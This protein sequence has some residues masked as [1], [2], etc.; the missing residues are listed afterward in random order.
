MKENRSDIIISSGPSWRQF[1]Y[2][3]LFFLLVGSGLGAW[4]MH[5]WQVSDLKTEVAVLLEKLKH[6][7]EKLPV[8]KENVVTRTETQI[9]YVPKETIKY[10]D[11]KTGQE[12]EEKLDGKFDIGKTE[13]LYS[14][15]G[16]L[17][18]FTKTDDEKY[19]F[20]KNMMK[21]NQSS[22]VKLEVEVP[23]VDKTKRNSLGGWYTNQGAAISVGHAPTPNLEIKG[24]VGVPDPRKL[25]GAGAEIRF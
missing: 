9:A 5:T 13:F 21:L 14:V 11:A 7:K 10:I 3:C 4:G 24:I 18:K 16:K 19:V 22:I 20:E 15:N 17:G 8:I 1:A 25:Y 2:A 6:E 23:T 12:V